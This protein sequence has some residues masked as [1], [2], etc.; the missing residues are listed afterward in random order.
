MSYTKN[1]QYAALKVSADSGSSSRSLFISDIDHA[2]VTVSGCDIK[3]S[4]EPRS[5]PISVADGKN[6]E[7]VIIENVPVGRDRIV[8][9]KAYDKNGNE[10]S[11]Y[12]MRAVTDITAGAGNYVNVTKKTTAFGNVLYGIKG[13]YNFEELEAD[14]RMNSIR[15]VIDD[16]ISPFL[17]N[18]SK[19][20]GELQGFSFPYNASK[21]DYR[22]KTGSVTFDYLLAQKFSV[23]IDDPL[24]TGL[25]ELS[26]GNNFSID[27]VVPGNWVITVKDQEGNVL[28]KSEVQVESGKETKLNHIEHNGVAILVKQGLTK[29]NKECSAVYYWKLMYDDSVPEAERKEVKSPS[30]PGSRIETVISTADSNFYILDFKKAS[31]VMLILNNGTKGD[32]GKYTG[33]MEVNQKGVYNVLSTGLE[34]LTKVSEAPGPIDGLKITEEHFNKCFID[35]PANKRFVV[36]LSESLYGSKPVSVKAV[37]NKGINDHDGSY[38]GTHYTMTRDASGFWYCSVPYKDVQSTN[39]CGQPSYNFNVNGSIKEPPKFVSEG[40]VYQKFDGKEGKK[41]FLCLIYSSQDEKEICSRLT[42]AKKCKKVSDFDLNTEAGQMQI[43]NFRKVPGTKNLYRSFHPYNDDKKDISDTSKMRMKYVAE[44]ADKAGIKADINLSDDKQKDATYS[45]PKY[46][47]S[48]IDKN[49]VLYMT[50]CSYSECYVNSDGEKFAGGVKKIV[51]FVNKTEGPYQIHCAIGTDRTGVLCAVLAGLC[52]ASWSEIEADYCKSIEM[53]IYEY[54]GPG[55]VK[56]ALQNLLGVDF[57]E[58]VPDLQKAL[59]EKLVQKG[60]SSSDLEKMISRL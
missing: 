20:I 30:Y 58:E 29:S 36:L 54:R 46:Y 12:R 33:N 3:D 43:S 17:F 19:L 39:Q 24:S 53:G 14:E 48:I 2:I 10:I 40:Y 49:A 55:A 27:N 42:K 52:G 57:I 44:L 56:Y 60:I 8:T 16:S 6:A 34:A 7:N 28:D 25:S 41:K 59:K 1:T 22:L 13:I 15:N 51:Q 4:E 37:F 31:S 45:M 18:S 5:K 9:V 23:S 50:D 21:E 47:Q 38:T 32:D 11:G 35:D 26:A